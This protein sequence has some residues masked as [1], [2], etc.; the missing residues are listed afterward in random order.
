[1]RRRKM[2]RRGSRKHFTRGALRVHRK[3]SLPANM[4]MRGGFRL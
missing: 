1:M 4:V 3:N 2:S